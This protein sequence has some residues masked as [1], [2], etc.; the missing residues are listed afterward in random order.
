M[1]LSVAIPCWSMGG[2]GHEVLDY[3]FKI[4]ERQ[5]L[6]DFEVVVTDHSIDDNV[7]NVC[8]NSSLN[9][10][11][12]RN[13][14]DRGNP[15]SN[16]NLGLSNCVGDYIKLLC[17]D[18]YLYDD[19][20]LENCYNDIVG[21]NNVWSFNSYF[22]TNDYKNL[23]RRYFPYFNERIETVNTFGTPSALTIKNGLGIYCDENLKF[24]YDCEFYKRIYIKHGLPN[25]SDK[26]TMV[27][28]IHENSTTNTIANEQLRMDEENYIRRKHKC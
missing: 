13:E 19:V 4:L 24:A 10:K 22:H 23:Y 9:V 8:D 12:I 16:T 20:S 5:T 21:S 26:V 1:K 2:K 28:Y 15:A 6:K 27:N 3:S 17:Q 18:D 14:K 11:Y 7:K 25:L